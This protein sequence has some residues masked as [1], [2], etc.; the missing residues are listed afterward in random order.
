MQSDSEQWKPVVGYEGFYEVSNHGRVRALFCS[1][2]FHKPGRILKPW[3][4]KNGYVQVHLMKPG[5][6]RAAKC[7][8]ILVLEAFRGPA[9]ENC[10]SRHLNAVR[11]DNSVDNLAWGTHKQNMQDSVLLGRMARGE[12]QG[13]SKL[14]SQDV[15]DIRAMR[16]KGVSLREIAE[17]YNVHVSNVGYIVNRKTWTH[18]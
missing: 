4:L 7:I 15:I 16:Q 12:R 18:L 2:N 10:E 6:K 17:M 3:V 8:H 11:F 5:S 14:N 9:P 1:S 13:A